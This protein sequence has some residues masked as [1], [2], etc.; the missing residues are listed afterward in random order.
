MYP[1]CTELNRFIVKPQNGVPLS[2]LERAQTSTHF[3]GR[4]LLLGLFLVR[5]SLL[6]QIPRRVSL[7]LSLLLSVL[8]FCTPQSPA[9]CVCCGVC[10]C[11]VE[12]LEL[13]LRFSAYLSLAT[14]VRLLETR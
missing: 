7:Q 9:A 3:R 11:V 13:S 4:A 14:S 10:A 2:S 5:A 12:A 6:P 8:L 1:L